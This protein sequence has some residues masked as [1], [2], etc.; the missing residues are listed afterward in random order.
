MKEWS[1]V[2]RG[3]EQLMERMAPG[4]NTLCGRKYERNK[5]LLGEGS[6]RIFVFKREGLLSLFIGLWQGAG[7]GKS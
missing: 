3:S 4:Q 2:K 6:D 1:R 7:R 5:G